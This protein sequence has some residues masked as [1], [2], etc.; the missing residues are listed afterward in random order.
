VC[1]GTGGGNRTLE[2]EA[3]ELESRGREQRAVSKR[4]K[5]LAIVMLVENARLYGTSLAQ[6]FHWRRPFPVE[7]LNLKIKNIGILKDMIKEK[8]SP[9]LNYVAV[10]ESDHE[11]FLVTEPFPIDDLASRQPPTSSSLRPNKKL[12][13]SSCSLRCVVENSLEMCLNKYSCLLE[14]SYPNTGQLFG[15]SEQA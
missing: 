13:W 5:R 2:K 1:Q 10:S 15:F 4:W 8:K 3:Q 6:L 14:R 12:A 11:V 7:V 9:H